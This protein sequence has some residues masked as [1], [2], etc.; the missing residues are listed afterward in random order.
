MGSKYTNVFSPVSIRGA[1]YKNRL[2]MAPQ[3]PGYA[4]VDGQITKEYIDFFQPSARGGVAI[5][6]IGNSPVD[7]AESQDE[8]RHID[9]GT[10]I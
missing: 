10:D 7:M 4:S 3:S 8:T 1:I 2:H 9:L 6:T 5:I